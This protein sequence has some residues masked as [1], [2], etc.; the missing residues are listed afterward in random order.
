MFEWLRI[1]YYSDIYFRKKMG[2]TKLE[3]MNFEL[4]FEYRTNAR[5]KD[6]W[7]KSNVGEQKNFEI[8]SRP[9]GHYRIRNIKCV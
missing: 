2:I 3:N 6:A 5:R 7:I 1:S 9:A 8:S 4:K